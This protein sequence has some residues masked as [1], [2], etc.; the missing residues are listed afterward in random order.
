M[1]QAAPTE[2]TLGLS[3][4]TLSGGDRTVFIDLDEDTV[5]KLPADEA[6]TLA[7]FILEAIGE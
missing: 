2:L 3:D 5:I 4:L 7:M 6:R 1:T